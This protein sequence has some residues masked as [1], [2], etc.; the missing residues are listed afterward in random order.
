MTTMRPV[1]AW[2][3]GW[4]NASDSGHLTNQRPLQEN[5]LQRWVVAHQRILIWGTFVT[6]SFAQATANG[7]IIAAGNSHSLEITSD[8]ATLAYGSNNDG[9]LG[10]GSFTDS[11]TPVAVRGL[12][13]VVAVA[14]GSGHSIALKSDGTVWAWGFNAYGQLGNGTVNQSTPT[15]VAVNGLTGV[16]AIAAEALSAWP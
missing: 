2:D 13:G 8:G 11:G 6:L 1:I 12:T 16:V 5:R 4:S 7:P 10:N 14:G 15:P 3:R 9:Q